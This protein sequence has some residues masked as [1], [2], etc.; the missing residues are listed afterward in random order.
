MS[1]PWTAKIKWNGKMACIAMGRLL[2]L[3]GRVTF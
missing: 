2:R 3:D 1:T